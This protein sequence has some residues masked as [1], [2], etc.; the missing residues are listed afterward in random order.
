MPW[1][2]LT[3]LETVGLAVLSLLLVLIFIPSAFDVQW[4]CFGESIAHNSADTYVATFAVFGGLGW[5]IA[6]ALTASASS[7][8]RR[9]LALAIPAV[10]FGVLV[11]A[12]LVAAAAI[13]P[14]SC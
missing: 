12:S 3:G 9:W 6:G 13:A 11:G 7:V 8:G 10:W 4:S 2:L 1:G 14:I 5:L